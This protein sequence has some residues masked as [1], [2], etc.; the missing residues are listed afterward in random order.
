V[1][2]LAQPPSAAFG[3][4]EA[5]IAKCDLIAHKLGLAEGMQVLDVGCGW[6]VTFCG[7]QAAFARK[8]VSE[9]GVADR[10]EIRVQD[11]REVSDGPYDAIASIGMAE[12]VGAA[13]LPVPRG[14]RDRTTLTT[15]S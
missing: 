5:Q 6:G 13:M 12:H 4:T 15:R 3:L 2:L 1:R 9:Q 8:R 7:E 14:R 10:V 11:Y